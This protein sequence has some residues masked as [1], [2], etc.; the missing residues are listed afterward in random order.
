MSRT[1]KI[2]SG[3]SLLALVLS[4]YGC[5]SSFNGKEDVFIN[6]MGREV[7]LGDFR[8]KVVLMDFIFTS[9][10]NEG[11]ERMTAQFLRVQEL[12]KNRLEKDLFLLSVSI[13][14]E[15]DT[16]GTLK[17]YARKFKANPNVWFF[18]T[19]RPEAVDRQMK[20]YG[21]VWMKTGPDGK[22][23]HKVVMALLDRD[24][25]KAAEYND[26]NYDTDKIIEDIT[27]ALGPEK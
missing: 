22:R 18:L 26:Y 19:G 20:K 1:S 13:D 17:A 10:P 7:R 24:G 14:P 4:F 3:I 25:R 27:R 9:C 16:A 11:C 15:K 23:H 5:S 8:G 2:I 12:L 21:V 6:Q